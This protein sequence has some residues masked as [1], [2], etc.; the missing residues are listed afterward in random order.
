MNLPAGAWWAWLV[1]PASALAT[2]AAIAYARRRRMLDQPGPRRAHQQATPR[3]GGIAPV[4]LI[5][6]AGGA[7]ALTGEHFDPAMLACV[8]ALAAVAGIGWV[9]DH[10]PLPATPRLVVHVLAAAVAWHVLVGVPGTLAGFALAAL[11]VLV[12]A[13]MTNAWNFMDGIDGLASSQAMWVLALPLLAGWLGGDWPLWCLL[14]LAALAGFL[15][16]N[17]PRARIFLGDVGSGALGFL[18]AIVLLQAVVQGH[19]DAPLALL[20]VSAFAVDAGLTLATR[21]LRGR[22]WWRPHR[23]HLYQWLV[24]HRHRHAVVAG[25][26]TVWTVLASAMAVLA[27]AQAGAVRWAVTFAVLSSGALAW[28]GLRRWLWIAQRARR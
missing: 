26:Y 20:P 11:G 25:A 1:A 23:D 15:P 24:R 21:M 7:L 2:R 19:L 13:G 6:L 5:V 17:A 8:A 18:V 10:R 22:R 28:F 3:G 27:N 9:D 4:A 12:V 14:A 16:F